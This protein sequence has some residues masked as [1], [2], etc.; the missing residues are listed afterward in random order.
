MSYEEVFVEYFLESFYVPKVIC[1]HPVCIRTEY[2]LTSFIKVEN[3]GE[4]TKYL[5]S[6]GEV[7]T[8]QTIHAYILN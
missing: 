4:L 2:L 1:I 8:N 7:P 5:R 6:E 3:S